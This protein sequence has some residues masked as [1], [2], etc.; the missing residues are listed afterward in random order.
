MTYSIIRI[1]HPSLNKASRIIKRGLTLQEAQDHCGDP[2]TATEKRFD[3]YE[4]ED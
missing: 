4:Q 2:S 3:G 1:F